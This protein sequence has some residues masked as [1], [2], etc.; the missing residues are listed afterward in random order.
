MQSSPG[1]SGF[2]F[3]PLHRG[4]HT[5]RV[6]FWVIAS[7]T[8]SI[9]GITYLS[10]GEGYGS[11]VPQLFYFP[12]LYATYFYPDRGIWVAAACAAAYLTIT[13]SFIIPDP[14]II[15][16]VIFQTLLFPGIALGAAYIIRRQGQRR[17]IILEDE[18]TATQALIRGGE[19]DHVEFKLKSLWSSDLT[20]E[21]IVESNSSEVKKYRHNASK[22]II[23]RAM[24]G[25]LNTTGGD[26][27]IGIE[28]DR[29]NNSIRI[30]GLEDDYAKLHEEDRNPDGY[31][32]MIIESIVHKFLPE[33]FDTA[34]RFLHI[35]FPLVSGK[36]I[37]HVH[38]SPAEKPVLVNAGNDEILFIRTDA[39][40]RPISGQNLT[41]YI[42]ERFSKQG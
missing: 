21:E 6:R 34:S 40:T 5:D 18:S 22:F 28:E 35:S 13:A 32:R 19:N 42:L 2:A 14:F 12:I 8:I 29:I 37:C 9:T 10:V 39:T 7:I 27:L 41:D 24:A 1:L 4:S 15:G 31:R 36:T 33:I 26:L 25:F 20:K 23:A 16:G 17:F 11:V 38:I 30:A 3:L